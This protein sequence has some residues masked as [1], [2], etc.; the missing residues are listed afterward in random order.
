[1]HGSY[2]L[3]IHQVQACIDVGRKF[4]I[5]E[6]N[7]N[8]ARGSGLRVIGANGRGRVQDDHLL[9]EIE[10]PSSLLVLRGT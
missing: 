3:H 8:A 6:I 5:E 7:N 4:S 9:A 2:R 10:R 1:M